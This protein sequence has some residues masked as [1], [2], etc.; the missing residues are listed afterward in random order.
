[1]VTT[2]TDAFL[3]KG[4]GQSGAFTHAVM[5][6]HGRTTLEVGQQQ[7]AELHLEAATPV[8]L[9]IIS[10]IACK[11]SARRSTREHAERRAKPPSGAKQ[12][13]EHLETVGLLHR[14]F[15]ALT[16]PRRG[17]KQHG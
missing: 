4:A 12:E 1:M 3:T 13:V 14:G 9:H 5:Y 16:A 11:S 8:T 6:I 10:S 15:Q 17:H 7:M 2:D